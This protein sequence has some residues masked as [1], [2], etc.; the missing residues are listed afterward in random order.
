MNT[1]NLCR[2]DRQESLYG[3]LSASITKRRTPLN[4]STQKVCVIISLNM[5]EI[6]DI[7][8]ALMLLLLKSQPKL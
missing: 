8:P 7:Y 1:G 4:T 6:L 3:E 5:L 2:T